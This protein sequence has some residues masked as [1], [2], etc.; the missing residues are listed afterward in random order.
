MENKYRLHHIET[1][2][3]TREELI[4]IYTDSI[5]QFN[6]KYLGADEVGSADAP[7]SV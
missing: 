6:F 7:P 1:C 4:E 5:P 3:Y 2:E